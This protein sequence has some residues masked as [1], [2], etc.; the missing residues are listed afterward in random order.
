ME[1]EANTMVHV[2][3][4]NDASKIVALSIERTNQDLPLNTVCKI[5]DSLGP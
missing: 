5:L 4:R 3:E 2:H 1:Y